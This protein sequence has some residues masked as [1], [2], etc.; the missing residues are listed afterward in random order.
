M[1]SSLDYVNRRKDKL[2]HLGCDYLVLPIF[3]TIILT[4]FGGYGR[5]SH[6][7]NVSLYDVA[8]VYLYGIQAFT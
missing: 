5:G 3:I 4:S 7:A 2:R 6:F 8:S 1:V